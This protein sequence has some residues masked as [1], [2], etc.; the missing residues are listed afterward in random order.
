MC[1]QAKM[2]KLYRTNDTKCRKKMHE[3]LQ[4]S[5]VIEATTSLVILI[6]MMSVRFVVLVM[7]AMLP[8]TRERVAIIFVEVSKLGVVII[9]SGIPPVWELAI[10]V[11]V[12][13]VAIETGIL[14]IISIIWV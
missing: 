2:C 14:A 12:I 4:R 8:F 13:I 10:E 5:I 7:L 6:L 3:W 11:Q 9:C 1:D